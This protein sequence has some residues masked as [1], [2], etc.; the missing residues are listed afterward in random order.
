MT[1]MSGALRNSVSDGNIVLLD[2]R[3]EYGRHKYVYNGG[4]IFLFLT[5]DI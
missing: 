3:E 5:N 4:N 1:L 2:M